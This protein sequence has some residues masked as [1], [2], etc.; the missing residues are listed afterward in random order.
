MS[1]EE[2]PS[3]ITPYE[4]VSYNKERIPV[5]NFETAVNYIA[6]CVLRRKK[7]EGLMIVALYGNTNSGKTYFASRLNKILQD[8]DSR[9]MVFSPNGSSRADV[10]GYFRLRDQYPG[11]KFSLVLL[12]TVDPGFLVADQTS[13]E[14]FEALPETI[15]YIFNPN[16]ENPRPEYIREQIFTNRGGLSE[17]AVKGVVKFEY[18]EIIMVQNP[19]AKEK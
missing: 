2:I 5:V 15:L 18:P 19:D 17:S 11:F 10:A 6:E 13:A 3:K 1:S 12:Q 16:V 7:Q 4:V 8:K 9:E 14:V